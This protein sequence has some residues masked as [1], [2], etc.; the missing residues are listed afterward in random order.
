MADFGNTSFYRRGLDSGSLKFFYDDVVYWEIA[1]NSNRFFVTF[2]EGRHGNLNNKMESISTAEI[3]FP[4]TTPGVPSTSSFNEGLNRVTA[5]YDA[6]L[7]HD[8]TGSGGTTYPATHQYN[9]FIP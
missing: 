6:F 7:V 4:H 2:E 8:E 3:S 1:R 9:G 5:R